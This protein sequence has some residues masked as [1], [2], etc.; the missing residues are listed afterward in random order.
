MLTDEQ[1]LQQSLNEAG[2]AAMVPM[3]KQFDTNGEPIRINGIKHTVKNYAPQTYETPYGPVQVDRYTYQTYKGG[4]AYVPLEEDSRMVLNSTPRYSQIVAGK[5]ARFGADAIC[6]DLLECNGRKLSRNY[7]KKLSDFVGSI[8]QCHESEWEYDLPQFD[9]P[10]HSIT[11]GLDGTCM[12]I[13]KD[14]WREAM[15]GSIAFYD[16]QGERLHTIYCSA[17]PEY[18]KE[19]FKEKFSREIEQVK[20]KFPDVLYIGLADGAKDNW[21]FLRKYTKRL[22]L[23]FY[24]AREYISKAASAIFGRDQ[25]NKK[26]WEDNFSHDLKHKQGTAGRFI[27]ELEEQRA[28]LDSKNFIERDEE[29]RKVITYYKNHKSKMFYARHIKDNLPI[30][31]GVTEAA[32]KTLVKQRM[33]ISGSRWK[34][35]GASCVLALRTLKLT[36]GRWQQFWGYVMRHG[37]TLS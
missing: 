28:N 18:G 35:D 22:L 13:H 3:I 30:G 11:I 23:D 1:A 17:T 24:H 36:K 32:C 26:I 14:G 27:K 16:N 33:C 9:Q 15:C 31:S 37:C 10:V 2:Q 25:T 19:K 12:L 29:I 7:A 5:Y 20:E 4:R 34:D 21:T 6:D 8:A